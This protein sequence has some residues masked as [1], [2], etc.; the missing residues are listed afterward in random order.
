MNSFLKTRHDSISTYKNRRKALFKNHV[1]QVIIRN[2]TRDLSVML[3]ARVS[4]PESLC[5][6]SRQI[7]NP[8]FSKVLDEI[9][10]NLKNGLS[11]YS[12]LEFYPRLFGNLFT[13]LVRV[14][15]LTGT[16]D[17]MFLR[18]S[19]YLEKAAGLR[20]KFLQ[21]MVYPAMVLG[22]AVLSVGFLLFY[23]I[24]AFTTIFNNFEIEL[25]WLTLTILR[26]SD[27]CRDNALPLGL[28]VMVF[29]YMVFR[30]KST[31]WLK[32]HVD[33]AIFYVPLLGN[34]VRKRYIS[35]SCR[36]LGTLLNSGISL[37]QAIDVT[38][39]SCGN[40]RVRL[41]LITMKDLTSKG[42]K[43]AH[44]FKGSQLFPLMVIQMIAVGEETGNLPRML[45]KIADYYD[46]EIEGLTETL[47]SVIEPVVIVILGLIIGI[48]LIAIYLPLFNMTGFLG[49]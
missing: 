19:A 34:L 22:V 42:E 10:L 30:L 32:C 1:P 11:F 23:V 7:Q 5:I 36:I 6:L 45:L 16:L 8:A 26:I 41:E 15:E 31:A 2:F 20:K 47:S 44:S 38:A 12:C 43:L 17:E 21:V 49:D 35:F 18:I 25:P 33:H 24:P 48:M 39:R 13:S 14:G 40:E 28:S 37:L 3:N 27:F 9:N 46:Q 29:V 4:L